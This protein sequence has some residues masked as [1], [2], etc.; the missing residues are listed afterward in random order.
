M[1]AWLHT[2]WK[3]VCDY[4]SQ[5]KIQIA[6]LLWNADHAWLSHWLNNTNTQPWCRKTLCLS[7]WV[8]SF[9]Y[10]LSPVW[11]SAIIQIDN[12]IWLSNNP[13]CTRFSQVHLSSVNW[14]KIFSL[15]GKPFIIGCWNGKV[16]LTTCGHF[17]TESCRF[18]NL[19]T[20]S[21]TETCSEWQYIRFIAVLKAA[22]TATIRVWP[23]CHIDFL[24]C[25][26]RGDLKTSAERRLPL[27]SDGNAEHIVSHRPLD[28]AMSKSWTG[29][30][31]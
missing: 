6:I 8:I 29:I 4:L 11:R 15:S 31:Y 19:R 10:G 16:I 23:K 3:F 2:E 13:Y 12:I 25:I 21:G 7:N 1:D 9:V 17:C 18:D 27:P 26:A 14:R 22:V 28:R 5:P 20:V 24:A 30:L